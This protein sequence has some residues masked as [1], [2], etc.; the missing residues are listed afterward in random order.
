[1]SFELET[2]QLAVPVVIRFCGFH[3]PCLLPSINI[4]ST[5]CFPSRVSMGAYRC[6]TTAHLVASCLSCNV[7][8]RSQSS[9]SELLSL[10]FTT[11]DQW[12]SC[13]FLRGIA[14]AEMSRA[15]RRLIQSKCGTA[16]SSARALSYFHLPLINLL[17]QPRFFFPSLFLVSST[18]SS[19]IYASSSSPDVL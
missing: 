19:I 8:C 6:Y 16:W 18:A 15:S 5:S 1:M 13:K 9:Y 4:S 14:G 3:L 10:R 2:I 12:S 7:L 11:H 17:F